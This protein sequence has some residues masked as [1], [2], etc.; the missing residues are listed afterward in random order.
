MIR[1]APAIVERLERG[2]SLVLATILS[3]AGSTPRTSGAKMIID[4]D[5]GIEG[6][7]GGGL[8]EAEVMQASA[9]MLGTDASVV[10]SY[11]LNL[12]NRADT[13]DMICGGRLDVL[14][15]P[16][17]PTA[18]SVGFFRR[19]AEALTGGRKCVLVTP[20]PS[21]GAATSAGQKRLIGAHGPAPGEPPLPPDLGTDV[22]EAAMGRRAPTTTYPRRAR[23]GLSA[24]N[25]RLFPAVHFPPCTTTTHGAPPGRPRRGR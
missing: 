22:L 16:I 25:S 14:L 23:Y 19:L 4:A 13:M 8:V 2:E 21:P 20:L 9:E 15:E 18:D 5:G 10:R 17:A 7:I 11:N 24:A 1:L 6:T 12:D 3:H